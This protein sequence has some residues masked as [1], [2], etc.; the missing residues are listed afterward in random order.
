MNAAL[1]S[2]RGKLNSA[3]SSYQQP[4]TYT[5]STLN[6]NSIIVC[7]SDG[8]SALYHNSSIGIHRLHRHVLLQLTPIVDHLNFNFNIYQLSLSNKF[9][10]ICYL[11]HYILVRFWIFPPIVKLMIFIIGWTPSIIY[12]L[13]IICLKI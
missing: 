8:R 12:P 13:W 5:L 9:N 4:Q 3:L 7:L 11:F 6:R 2:I 1:Q 10:Q